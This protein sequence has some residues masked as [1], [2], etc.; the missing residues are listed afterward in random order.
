M[1]DPTTPHGTENVIATIP[2]VTLT[3]G[4]M[5]AKSRL[6][7]L[8]I[9]NHRIIFARETT[10]RLKEVSGQLRDNAKAAGKGRM[11]QLNAQMGTHNV[12]AGKYASMNPAAV[13]I[14]DPHNF[15]VDLSTVKKVSMKT[16]V[17]D[18]FEDRL[19]IKT[20]GKKYKMTINGSMDRARDA[21]SKAGL[22]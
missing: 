21:L 22:T 19:T 16:N 4:F 15:A 8:I 6:H 17:G 14:E 13:L 18:N 20:T 10:A 2:N 3:A 9:T 5:G 7:I 12:L 1:S 11:G